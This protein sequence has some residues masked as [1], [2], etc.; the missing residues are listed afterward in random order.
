MEPTVSQT[1]ATGPAADNFAQRCEICDDLLSSD[2]YWKKIEMAELRDKC[3][4]CQLLKS[5]TARLARQSTYIS[6]SI[7]KN[8]PIIVKGFRTGAH[9][10]QGDISATSS[11]ILFSQDK[12][13]LIPDLGTLGPYS[14]FTELDASVSFINK[15][16]SE[17]RMQHKTCNRNN[18][19]PLP[20]RVVSIGSSDSDMRLVEM[21]DVSAPYVTLSH[22][23]GDK[24]PVKT[25]L[26]NLAGMTK[27][28][29]MDTLP[30]VFQQAISIVRKLKV[31]Y[32]WI[33]SLC[34]IQDSQPDWELESSQMCDYYERSYITLSTATSPNSTI[35]FLGLRDQRWLPIELELA[36]PEGNEYIYAQQMATTPNEKG[37]LF[38][39]AWAW[40]ESAMSTRVVSFTP[41]ELIWECSSHTVPERYIPDLVASDRLG[42]SRELA[43]LRFHLN[44]SFHRETSDQSDTDTT[45]KNDDNDTHSG[46]NTPSPT[47]WK[48]CQPSSSSSS[49]NS[50]LVPSYDEAYM[51][52]YIWDMWDNLVE[53]Y[54]RRE[55]TYI[56]D[57]LPALSGVASRVQEVTQSRYI[58]GMWEDNLAY[59]LCWAI[60]DSPQGIAALPAEY[61]APS[62]SWASVQGGVE[63]MIE[64]TI[65]KFEPDITII[66]AN[67]HVPG[68]NPFGRVNSG[69]LILRG[70]TAEVTLTCTN[71]S[72]LGDYQLSGPLEKLEF[73]PDCALISSNGNI[74]RAQQGQATSANMMRRTY[75]CTI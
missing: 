5:A 31:E 33:D 1:G 51:M 11:F 63:A 8:E 60:V 15:Q 29:D 69:H 26:S 68:L 67:C 14:A 2:Q 35:P 72:K 18:K 47:P 32:I 20:T 21:K 61:V 46:T 16:L 42:I 23:W 40:Q 22:C 41:S 19:S 17:C 43:N 28:I 65:Q 62:W 66:E 13:R 64:R 53:T 38:S 36:T 48:E 45:E 24:Q 25:T 57:K 34:I 70:R 30:V 50:S 7:S 75:Q 49:S 27:A 74:S 55:L 10:S 73:V 39:R 52:N 9:H 3:G 4:F 6:L 54:S 71:P 12:P 58:A 59:N 37:K 44:P 56:T